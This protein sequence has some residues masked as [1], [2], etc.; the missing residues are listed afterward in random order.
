MGAANSNRNSKILRRRDLTL[1]RAVYG[2][3]QTLHRQSVLAMMLSVLNTP[4][5]VAL[6]IFSSRA[7]R[8]GFHLKDAR[9]KRTS[10]ASFK[11][12]GPGKRFP[13]RRS[14]S[15]S[16]AETSTTILR[17]LQK[18]IIPSP[19]SRGPSILL[20]AVLPLNP[21]RSNPTTI[22]S[23]IWSDGWATLRPIHLQVERRP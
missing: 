8:Y 22:H 2:P 14:T 9:S 12:E 18:T 21:Q 17:M 19:S 20:S 10:L 13:T 7:R 5:F 4:R 1:R 11:R 16:V 23:Q 15:T 3:S 6:L